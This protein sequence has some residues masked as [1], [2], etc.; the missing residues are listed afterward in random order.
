MKRIVLFTCILI[1]VSLPSI[2]HTIDYKIIK[3]T[4]TNVWLHF[5]Q[6]GIKHII[7]LGLDH[8]LFIACIYFLNT[9]LKS[10]L[11]QCTI[12]TIA[13]SITLILAANGV[14]V[15]PPTIIEPI[16]ALSIAVLAIENILQKQNNRYRL[17]IITLFGLVHGMGFA[18]ALSEL[19]LAKS[20]FIKGLLAFNIGVEIGQLAVITI[21][22]LAL[23]TYLEHKAFYKKYIYLPSNIA[24]GLVA[25]YWTITRIQF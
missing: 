7:P 4:Y 8:I 12:F 11:L 23:K 20:D 16:I 21:L 19:Q 22:S 1:I 6:Q 25:L 10:I 3:P 9:S 5:L 15:V 14:L 13:H 2:A 18:S 17:I 24:I